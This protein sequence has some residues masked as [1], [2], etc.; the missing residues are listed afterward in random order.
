M[1][2]LTKLQALLSAPAREYTPGF[3]YKDLTPIVRCADGSTMSVQASEY[4]YCSPRSNE[5][6]YTCVEVWNCGSPEAW[7]EWGNG[8]D[9]YAYIPINIVAAEINRRG[10]FAQTE[11]DTL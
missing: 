5:G 10:G 3:F 6:P 4:H 7:T 2:T 9:P 1:D 8:E 11:P